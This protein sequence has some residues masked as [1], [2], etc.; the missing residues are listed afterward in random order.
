MH[1]LRL[2]LSGFKSFVDPV[3]MRIEPGL[4]GIVGPNGCGKSN[5]LEALRWVMG[6]NSAK[7]MRGGGMDDVI[8]SGSSSRPARNH[9][10]VTLTIDNSQRRA[11]APFT[12]QPMLEVVRRIDRG[13][14]STY[15]ING[16]EVRARDV[17]L[18]FADASTGANSPALVRQGQISELI[19]ARPQNRRRI[20]EEAA[21]VSG[22]HTRRHEAELRVR[23][24]EA[25][26]ARLG[27]VMKELEATL[28]RLRRETR[29]ASAFRRLSTEIRA[30]QSAVLYARWAEARDLLT[31]LNKESGEAGVAVETA[32][33]AASAAQVEAVQ[34]EA[35]IKPLRDEETIA[36][37]VLHRLAIEKDRLDQAA[38]SATAEVA[39]CETE[40]ARI[41]ADSVRETQIVEDSG[42]ALVRLEAELAEVRT[43]VA[44][45]PARL[46]ELEEQ[47][48][49]LDAE[50]TA[51]QEVVTDLSSR[52]AA[53]EAARHAHEQRLEDARARLNKTTRALDQVKTDREALGP[54]TDSH[55]APA[56]V[57]VALAEQNLSAARAQLE[58]AE[59]AHVAATQSESA[60]RAALRNTDDDLRR[61]KSEAEGLARLTQTVTGKGFPA[62]LDTV[63]PQ[64]G[65]EAALAAALGDDLN[66]ALDPAAP[67]Y[68][69]GAEAALPAW[70]LGARSLAP[71][72][73]A[74]LALSTRLSYTA[75][76]DRKDG[77]TLQKLLA[78]GQR[79]VSREGDL[80]RWDGFTSRADAPR[81]AAIRLEQKN[82]LAT[83]MASIERLQPTAHVAA[84]A[85]Y[86][87]T[88]EL[89]RC[90]EGLRLARLAPRA[91]ETLLQEARTAAADL[92]R[93]GARREA[94]VQ[95]L[96]DTIVRFEMERAEAA[97][98]LTAVTGETEPAGVQDD[99]ARALSSGREAAAA[100]QEA[101]LS[102]R[103]AVNVELREHDLRQG[104]MAALARDHADWTARAD[105]SRRRLNALVTARAAALV[106]LA[107]ARDAP[108]TRQLDIARTLDELSTAEAR[109]AKSS[110]A[111]ALGEGHWAQA[112]RELRA[113]EVEMLADNIRPT[114][115]SLLFFLT[116]FRTQFN[117]AFI[118]ALVLLM[119]CKVALSLALL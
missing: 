63:N 102:A 89:H 19:S 117:A 46:P 17:Q 38:Q 13:E 34:A 6:A 99:L 9:A 98:A 47:A 96:N 26:L 84:A 23:A 68:W 95:A 93:D 73:Q 115:M 79:L 103:T 59:A 57:K 52:I 8:F 76:V 118:S 61:L 30:L 69:G 78:P 65:Y 49:A 91:A 56:K 33:R 45:A 92:E 28:G 24:A 75:L 62:A 108:S 60:A 83:V 110:D 105:A 2:R 54:Q 27:D 94:Q 107:G 81:P 85:H 58:A 15:R 42:R 119:F 116:I 4:T 7:A 11:P 36:A 21:G 18:L 109:K 113:A 64:A 80:W 86:N 88:T 40:I 100:A 31:R 66:A 48:T 70:P 71:L 104:R 35:A 77:Q 44:S 14:G 5:L 90:V 106:A 12:D 72:I 41:D 32:T 53:T 97:S 1:F 87:A 43:E 82:R 67:A 74:P 51:A 55:L 50:R 25:N 37:A 10:E 16:R 3:E 29:Q 114:V 112:Q 22:L 39:R 101:A 20:L 111:L